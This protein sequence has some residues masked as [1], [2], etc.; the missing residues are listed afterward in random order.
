MW[1]AARPLSSATMR[2]TLGYSF[3]GALS[4]RIAAAADPHSAACAA[5]VESAVRDL[6]V[7]TLV[8]EHALKDAHD[9]RCD[10]F[11]A[12][13]KLHERLD[14]LEERLAKLELD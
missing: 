6:A 8:A 9:V 14:A 5:S 2:R 10:A 11:V 12:A 4:P 1:T 13:Q 7:R 3:P